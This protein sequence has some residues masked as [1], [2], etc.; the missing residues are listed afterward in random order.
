MI[1]VLHFPTDIYIYIY[2]PHT[3]V[4]SVPPVFC[5]FAIRI[6]TFHA[7]VNSFSENS[8]LILLEFVIK[9]GRIYR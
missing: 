6:E 2:A 5:C 8:A 4:D 1:Q 3:S 9:H 7:G